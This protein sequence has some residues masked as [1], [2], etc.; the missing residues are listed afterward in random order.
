MP[1]PEIPLVISMFKWK[2]VPGEPLEKSGLDGDGRLVVDAEAFEDAVGRLHA[3][4]GRRAVDVAQRLV[5]V[6]Q[7]LAQ[8]TRHRLAAAGDRRVFEERLRRT[9]A[10]GYAGR[11]VEILPHIFTFSQSNSNSFISKDST[12]Q[13]FHFFFHFFFTGFVEAVW[14]PRPESEVD[15]HQKIQNSEFKI[16]KSLQSQSFL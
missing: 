7:R 10:L 6:A 8:E 2:S 1:I 9:V 13:L 12:S 3:A 14:D 16:Q 11:H 15:L 4:Q 5:G